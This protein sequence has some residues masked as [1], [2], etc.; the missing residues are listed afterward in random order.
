[1]VV[2]CNGFGADLHKPFVLLRCLAQQCKKKNLVSGEEP[3]TPSSTSK[4]ELDGN[5]PLPRPLG[6]KG[7]EEEDPQDPQDPGPQQEVP[8]PITNPPLSA[9]PLRHQHP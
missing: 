1:M 3:R 2:F 4:Q 6:E 7:E 8:P 5:P 9:E